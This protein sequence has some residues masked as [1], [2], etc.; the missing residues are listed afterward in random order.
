MGW[1]ERGKLQIKADELDITVSE[2]VDQ[3]L[4]EYGSIYKAAVQL[5]VYPNTIRQYLKDRKE[6]KRK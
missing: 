2:L 6:G 5:G 3:A 1:N 4:K